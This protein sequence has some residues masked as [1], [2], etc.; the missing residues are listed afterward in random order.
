M[1]RLRRPTQLLDPAAVTELARALEAVDLD[2]VLVNLPTTTA[3]AAAACGFG[4]GFDGD[5]R[6]YL[7][8]HFRAMR[9]F[10]AEAARRR[11]C[12]IVWTD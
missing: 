2:A 6:G 4:R 11:H 8:E 12:V 7:V 3:D 10:Y 1:R 5:V 9:E